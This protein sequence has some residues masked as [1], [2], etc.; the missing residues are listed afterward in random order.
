VQL[1]ERRVWAEVL[2]GQPH[3]PLD[4]CFVD[5]DLDPTSLSVLGIFGVHRDRPGFSVVEVSGPRSAGLARTDGSRLFAS[6]L[7][8]GSAAHLFSVAGAEELLELGW[9]SHELGAGSQALATAGSK[10]LA[11]ST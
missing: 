9:R 4:G 5:R 7:A 3:E 8:G 11:P 2:P 1:P 10:L 6:T